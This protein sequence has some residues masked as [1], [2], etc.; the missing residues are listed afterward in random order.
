MAK[1][2]LLIGISKYE[3][4]LEPL[5]ASERDV[6]AMEKVL[7]HPEMGGFDA[8]EVITNPDPQQMREKIEALFSDCQ[9]DDLLLLYFSGHGITNNR[10]ILYLATPLTQKNRLAATAIQSDFVHDLMAS[11]P[12]RKQVVILDCCFSGA[13]AKGMTAK[14]DAAVLTSS[15]LLE[16]SKPGSDLSVYTRFLVEGIETGAA[17]LDKDSV[18]SVDELHE[19]AKQKVQVDS[20]EMKPEIHA[21]KAGYKIS[22]AQT[23][24][25]SSQ[26]LVPI[27][28]PPDF[29]DFYGRQTELAQVERAVQA[30]PVVMMWGESGVGKTYLGAQLAKQLSKDYKVCWLDKEGLTL[31]ELLFQMNEF[32]KSNGEYGFVITYAESKIK[33]KNKIPTLVQVISTSKVAKYIFFIDSFQLAHHSEIKPFVERFRTY[34]GKNRVVLIDHSPDRSLEVLLAAKVQQY[35]VQGFQYE[36]AVK[37]INQRCEVSKIECSVED[38]T[39]VIEKTAG[40]PLAIELIIQWNSLLGVSMEN[41]LNELVEYDKRYGAELNKRLLENVAA[42]LNEEERES[43]SHLSVFRTPVKRSAW[44]YLDISENL[45]ESLLQRRLLTRVDCDKFQMHPLIA[46]FWRTSRSKE[47]ISGWHEKAAQYYWDQGKQSQLDTLDRQAYLEAHYHWRKIGQVE[48][49]AQVLNDLVGRLHEKE[50]LPSERLPGLKEWLV[51]LEDAIFVHKPWLLLD[52]GR[53]LEKQGSTKE[54]KDVFQQ[55]YKVFEQQADKLGASVALYYVGKMRHFMR[56]PK[57]ALQALESV[58]EMAQSREDLPMQIRSLGKMVSCYTDLG[59]YEDAQKTAQRAYELAENSGDNLGLALALYRKGSIE[60]QQSQFSNAEDN[61]KE[62][63]DKF[64]VLGDIYRQSKSLARLGICQQF[65][66][67]LKQATENLERAIELKKSIN[68]HHGLARDLDYLAD[69]YSHL[70]LYDKAEAKYRESLSIKE[71]DN[72]IQPDLYGQIKAYNNLARIALLSGRLDEADDL[73]QKSEQRIDDKHNKQHIGVKGTQLRIQ[74]DLQ[75]TKGEYESALRSYTEA[76]A[77]FTYPNPEVPHSKVRVLFSRGRTYLS[78]GNLDLAK[79][80]LET[81]RKSFQDYGMDYDQALVLTYLARLT[82][83]TN[84]LEEADSQNQEAM[85]IAAQKDAQPV[86]IVC[87]ETQGLIEEKKILKS[88]SPEQ[89]TQDLIEPVWKW[90]DGAIQKLTEWNAVL[91]V[92]RLQVKNKLWLFTVKYLCKEPIS[93][94]DAYGLLRTEPLTKDVIYIELLNTKYSLGILKSISPQLAPIIA[95][96]ALNILAPLA[97]QFGFNELREE[98]EELALAFLHPD[99]YERI[100]QAL[101]ISFP[102]REEF[103]QHLTSELE[104]LLEDAKIQAEIYPRAKT[105]YS[106]YKKLKARQVSLDKILDIVGVRIIT[107]TE[108]ECYKVLAFV[109]EIGAFFQGEGTLK[110][111]LRDYIK[112]PKLTGYQSIHINIKYGDPEPRIV[113]FQI[114]T[115]RMHLAAEVGI[116]LLGLDR[117]AHSRY[118]NPATYAR[119]SSKKNY[120][121]AQRQRVKLVIE[122]EKSAMVT[123]GNIL[124]SSKF[125]LFSVDLDQPDKS[126]EERIILRLDLAAKSRRL[127]KDQEELEEVQSQLINNIKTVHGVVRVEENENKSQIKVVGLSLENKALLLQDLTSNSSD[128]NEFI[129]LITPKGDVK[130]LKAGATPVDF[131]YRI[132]T[133]LGNQYAGAKVNGHMVTRDTPLKNGAMVEIITQKNS[134]PSLEWLNFVVTDSARNKIRQWYKRSHWEENIARGRELLQKELGKNGFEALLES[135]PMQ[136]VVKQFNYHRVDD[137][138]ANLGYGEVSL[139]QVSHRIREAKKTQQPSEYTS[140]SSTIHTVTS[141]ITPTSPSSRSPI[142]GVEGLLYRLA[143]CCNPVP[144]EQ[145]IGVVTLGGGGISIHRK[146]CRNWE[147]V[148]VERIINVSWN[149]TEN[150][151]Y[152]VDVQIEVID[153]IGVSANVLSCF[154]DAQINVRKAEVNTYAD[155]RAVIALRIDICNSEQLDR[156]FAKIKKMKGFMSLRR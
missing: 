44:T 132:H 128:L 12:S 127:G 105:I 23:P 112:H 95:D 47:E 92:A 49:A 15:G 124:R 62:S 48:T 138:L 46:E 83:F 63:A 86:L 41:V 108:K 156:V 73:L 17:D 96:C 97:M 110:E 116:G 4:G 14:A 32:L 57:L 74:G 45:G 1:L 147:N 131:A 75:F 122:C 144:G 72:D 3:F 98:L 118:K 84:P 154:S 13:F 119:P 10:G 148:P 99:E 69:I 136:A 80:Y 151:T 53:K 40:H 59:N 109:Q 70:G 115:H 93:Q 141:H 42:H 102:K 21:V 126:S 85:K 101:E 121:L 65:Q 77:C 90:Y 76:E 54:A 155:S 146:E 114:R 22:L 36:E 52:K 81:S 113:E 19:Y 103:I 130:K 55:A 153:R 78:L 120:E 5:P 133:D 6:Q 117:A 107:Q 28:T 137:L 38:V 66:G 7:K 67:K 11:S 100:N 56:Q 129:Y 35:Q 142:A 149:H 79:Q 111:S 51:N 91:A 71:G 68:D 26:L 18:I 39:A 9:K 34:G 88:F 152:P 37:Y 134:H 104:Y 24:I 145:I 50:R 139:N 61:F 135:E 60:R 150:Q 123:V 140:E 30:L 82:A 31:D 87:L 125:E 64:A 29:P 2:A 8:V 20:T 94:D 27:F 43:L 25:V 33:S 106:I 143:R 89:A 58:L 16:Y